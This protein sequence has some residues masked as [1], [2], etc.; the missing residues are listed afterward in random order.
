MTDLDGRLLTFSEKK[1]IAKV[2]KIDLDGVL[3]A[4]NEVPR[5]IIHPHAYLNGPYQD[6]RPKRASR[7]AA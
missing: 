7:T 1:L 3:N 6:G 2:L 5:I 4:L